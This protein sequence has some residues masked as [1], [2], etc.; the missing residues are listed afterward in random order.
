[1]NVIEGLA[2]LL[3]FAAILIGGV[4]FISD[5]FVALVGREVS[6]AGNYAG[7]ALAS[8]EPAIRR[9]FSAQLAETKAEI[10]GAYQNISKMAWKNF[11]GMISK[12][13]FDVWNSI[14]K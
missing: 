2:K 13:I 6:Q 7:G 9:D 14:V 12:K 11:T 4:V 3:I 1:M 8:R 5:N 10:S